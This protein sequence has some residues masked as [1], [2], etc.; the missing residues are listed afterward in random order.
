MHMDR[1]RATFEISWGQLDYMDE[2][3]EADRRPETSRV[4]EGYQPATLDLNACLCG[5]ANR[6]LRMQDGTIN[7]VRSA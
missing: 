7:P 2:C 5:K 4:S 1:W 3:T 6:L